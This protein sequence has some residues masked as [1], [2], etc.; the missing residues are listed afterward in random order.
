MVKDREVARAGVEAMLARQFE[1][2][3]VAHGDVLEQGG[4]I[5]LR[6]GYDWLLSGR[7]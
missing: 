7:A 6:A 2:V 3:V 1:R 4:P 5:A